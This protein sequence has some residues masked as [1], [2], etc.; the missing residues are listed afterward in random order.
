MK[1]LTKLLFGNTDIQRT[2][3]VRPHIHEFILQYQTG[4]SHDGKSDVVKCDC[5]QWA[6][7]HRNA[8]FRETRKYILLN[9]E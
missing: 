2:N 5:G 1:W 3:E 4:S 7:W 9:N 8:S 6:V